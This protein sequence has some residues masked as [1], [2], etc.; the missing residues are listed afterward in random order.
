[1]SEPILKLRGIRKV[2]PGVVALDG[3]DLNLHAGEVHALMGENG[4]GKSTA[5]KVLTGVYQRDDGT[6]ELDGRDINP[7]STLEA[8]AN[9]IS[10]VYQEVNLVGTL[11]IAENILL[12]RQPR[13]F[14]DSRWWKMNRLA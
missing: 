14:G 3:V 10:T 6:A 11:S 5:I 2:F 13:R 7:A 9:G 4:A 12:G 8:E 1:M